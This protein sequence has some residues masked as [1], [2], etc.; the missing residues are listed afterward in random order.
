MY[1]YVYM[2]VSMC[3]REVKFEIDFKEWKGLGFVHISN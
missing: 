2:Y 3:V 1:V